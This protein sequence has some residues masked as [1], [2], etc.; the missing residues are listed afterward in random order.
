[1]LQ[2]TCHRLTAYA[3]KGVTQ[4]TNGLLCYKKRANYATNR[5]KFFKFSFLVP[6]WLGNRIYRSWG[7]KLDEKT[8]N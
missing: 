1:M 7:P 3:T 4:E 6:V 8:E 2:E 5:I